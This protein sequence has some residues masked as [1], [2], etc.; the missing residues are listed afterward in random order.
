M[1]KIRF[2]TIV[3]SILIIT[4][5]AAGSPRVRVGDQLF[6]P[7]G[8]GEL[9]YYENFPFHLAHGWRMEIG[10][11]A[12]TTARGGTRLEIDGV[13]IPHDFIDYSR[14]VEEDTEYLVKYFVFNFS[15]GMTGVH[16]FEMF[17]SNICD[18][19]LD[20]EYVNECENPNEILEFS[21]K[22]WEV[23]F[24]EPIFVVY[25]PGSVEGYQWPVGN[26]ITINVNNGEYT[27]QSVSEP[28]PDFPEGE[29][30]VLFDNYLDD[31]W[32]ESGDY[33][34]LTDEITGATKS[35][36]VT[37]VEVTAY[38]I[39]AKT[40][41]GIY[42]PSYGLEVFLALEDGTPIETLDVSYDGINWTAT[43]DQLGSGMLCS[44]KQ[45]D[46]DFDATSW[47]FWIP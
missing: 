3:I 35:H 27:A 38:D 23:I 42:D 7:Q 37:S 16:T 13:P 30:R 44:A 31:Y 20:E 41:G 9:Y 2:F 14:I 21:I 45:L 11:P 19:W 24:Q 32:I 25:T 43:F 22:Y 46:A 26:T 1:K 8:T 39:N 18:F 47:D 33:V 5:V 29:T 34:V 17:Y 12:I 28:R 40:I 4:S 15:A 10:N 36:T 6:L